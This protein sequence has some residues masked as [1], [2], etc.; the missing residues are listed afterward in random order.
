VGQ[1]NDLMRLSGSTR[2]LVVEQAIPAIE[3]VGLGI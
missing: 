3:E 1:V 2:K